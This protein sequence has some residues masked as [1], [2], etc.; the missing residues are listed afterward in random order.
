MSVPGRKKYRIFCPD[1]EVEKFPPDVTVEEIYPA[2][3]L[4]LDTFVWNHK[5]YLILV[6]IGNN[7]ENTVKGRGIV[8][9]G[10]DKSSL[11]NRSIFPIFQTHHSRCERSEPRFY[12]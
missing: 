3:C 4:G 2:F 7:G 11:Y 10:L 8:P 12:Q 6:A 1:G 9:T 5:D